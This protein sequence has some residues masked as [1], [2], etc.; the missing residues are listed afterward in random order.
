MLRLAF[1]PLVLASACAVRQAKLEP[2]RELLGQHAADTRC[3]PVG[4]RRAALGSRWG[5]FL[6]VKVRA[7]STVTGDARLHVGGRAVPLKSFMVIEEG[8]IAE[9]EWP[10]DRL[11]VPAGLAKGTVIDLTLTGLRTPTRR[12]DE[13]AFIVE[14]GSFKPS[15]DEEEWV[16]TLIARGGPDVEAWRA[17]QR[18][19]NAPKPPPMPPLVLP[20]RS[21]P[22]SEQEW[23]AW[24]GEEASGDEATRWAQWPLSRSVSMVAVGTP[25]AKGAFVAFMSRP[26]EQ[27]APATLVAQQYRR[28]APRTPEDMA[29]LMDLV[30]AD[31]ETDDAAALMLFAGVPATRVALTRAGPA[32]P[33]SALAA[34][35]PG[36]HRAAIE[37]A[38]TALAL[39]TA[40]ALDWPIPASGRISSGFGKRVHP[41]R[42]VT[43]LHTGI[44]L[45]VPEGTLISATGPGVVVR[46]AEDDVNGRYLVIDH[47]H[48]VTTAYLH[49][50]RLLVDEGQLVSVGDPISESGNTGRSTGPHLHYQLELSGVPVDPLLFRAPGSSRPMPVAVSALE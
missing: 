17:A 23:A 29:A 15:V 1:L 25:L 44:D 8:V 31:V 33:F 18:A 34:Q 11:S 38:S 32:A 7:P 14:Q 10:N 40:F 21:L 30:R 26:A 27:R 5:E 46:A 49:N 50:S 13:L 24:H 22:S 43:H 6:R 28:P 39:A 36:T 4:I 9:A 41:T 3:G 20:G 19:A 35:L 37:P 47:G 45:P 48:G 42:R 2:A 16:A 12:C